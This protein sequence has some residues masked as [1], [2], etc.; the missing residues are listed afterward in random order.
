MIDL[1]WIEAALTSARPQALGA[2]V[3]YFRDLDV[4]EEAFQNASLRALDAWP[5]NGPPRNPAAW[6]ILV[7]RNSAIDAKRRQ[8][9]QTTLADDLAA[10]EAQLA[11]RLDEAHYRDESA[12]SPRW[13]I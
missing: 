10:D 1:A 5:K 9:K 4:A 13:S 2:L 6:L 11:D 8:Q 7:G 12:W 3:R